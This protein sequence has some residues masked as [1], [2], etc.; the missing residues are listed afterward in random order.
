MVC[1][2]VGDCAIDL[3]EPEKL[4]ILADRL[5]RFAAAKRVD[6]RIQRDSCPCNVVVAVPLYDIFLGTPLWIVLRNEEPRPLP[7]EMRA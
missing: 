6:D 1:Q 5:R 3:F 2:V 7:F 4:K